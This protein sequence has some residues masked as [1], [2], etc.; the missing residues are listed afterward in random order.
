MDDLRNLPKVYNPETVEKEWYRYWLE[1]G[2]FAPDQDLTREPFSIVMP[3]PNVTG[4]LHL[5]HALNNT[6]QDILTRWRRM[7]GYSV[8]WLPAPTMPA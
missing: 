4:S 1:Q 3:P 2:Y 7:Q 6:L 8:L 5:G